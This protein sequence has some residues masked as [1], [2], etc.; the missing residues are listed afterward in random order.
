MI[1]FC[2]ELSQVYA[3]LNG[4]WISKAIR[5][6]HRGACTYVLPTVPTATHLQLNCSDWPTL[7]EVRYP[8]TGPRQQGHKKTSCVRTNTYGE[9]LLTWA[10]NTSISGA[11]LP[12]KVP[13]VCVGPGWSSPPHVHRDN[14]CP[15][16]Y[17]RIPPRLWSPSTVAAAGCPLIVW[18][19][20]V[21]TSQV[22][23]VYGHYINNIPC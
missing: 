9:K 7:S 15:G 11:D 14:F 2:V 5:Q 3:W 13:S 1:M 10:S 6:C 23:Y 21:P 22:S 19:A 20:T 8:G 18:L 17:D 16:R 12:T 4:C